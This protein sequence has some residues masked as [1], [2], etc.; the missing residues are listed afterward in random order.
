MTTDDCHE[1][2]R[3]L[4]QGN[5]WDPTLKAFIT[6]C[7]TNRMILSSSPSIQNGSFHEINYTADNSSSPATLAAKMKLANVTAMRTCM[8]QKNEHVKRLN[9]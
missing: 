7:P 4:I 3:S 5:Y 1:S 6:N 8:A 9:L 2:S